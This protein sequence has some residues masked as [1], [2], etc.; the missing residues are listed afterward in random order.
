[1]IKQEFLCANDLISHRIL[2]NSFPCLSF[3]CHHNESQEIAIKE[4]RKVSKK[5]NH[6]QQ[7]K[8]CAQH[9]DCSSLHVNNLGNIEKKGLEH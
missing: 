8:Y 7:E 2:H 4:A 9:K 6:E 5:K 1:M 3:I